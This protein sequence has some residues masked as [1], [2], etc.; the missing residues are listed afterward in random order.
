MGA[1][2]AM[3]QQ[4]E[5]L[6]LFGGAMSKMFNSP[7]IATAV[8]RLIELSMRPEA[9]S[10]RFGDTF[11]SPLARAAAGQQM[12]RRAAA[13]NEQEFMRDLALAQAK[14]P[15]QQLTGETSQLLNEISSNREGLRLLDDMKSI[16]A[17]G[18]AG[19]GPNV[20]SSNFKEFFRL[21]GMDVGE[22]GT[23]EYRNK[24]ASYIANLQSSNSFGRELSKT[25]YETLNKIL[26]DPG[27]FSS[28]SKLEAQLK[29]LVEKLNRRNQE[30]RGRADYFGLGALAS[31]NPSVSVLSQVRTQR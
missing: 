19:G 30:L 12:E 24:V 8:D 31:G 9:L 5:Q 25:D 14:R 3:A 2:S 4:Q 27:V 23:E 26:T 7:L 29:P 28:A 13:T 1:G 16:V 22:T 17:K 21:L 6:G 11:I 20:A 18:E 10:P 15:A